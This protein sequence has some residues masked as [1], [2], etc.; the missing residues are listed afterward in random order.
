MK[1]IEW[2]FIDGSS[3][4][5]TQESSL[6]DFLKVNKCALRAQL[7]QYPSINSEDTI[8]DILDFTDEYLEREES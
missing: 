4:I 8:D 6:D 1:Q 3:I 5:L 2:K 7:G